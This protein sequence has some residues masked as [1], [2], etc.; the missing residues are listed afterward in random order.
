MA[1]RVNSKFLIILGA[2][3]LGGLVA[4][5]IVAGPI[6]N[7]VKGDRSKKQI[8]LADSL[9]KE[10]ATAEDSTVKREKLDTA[11]RNYQMA[12]ASDSRNPALLVKLGDALNLMT[13]YEVVVYLPA[14]RQAW[15]KALEID[16]TYLPAL[17]R[18]QDSYYKGLELGDGGTGAF[19]KL[20]DLAESIHKLDKKDVR[21]NALMYIAPLFR[22]AMNIET[23]PSDV[24]TAITELSS[25]IA[26]NPTAPEMP[27]MVYF[28]AR[29]Q[30]KK[31]VETKRGGQDKEGNAL[32]EE[33]RKTFSNAIAQDN[34]NAYLH[35]RF[36]ELLAYMRQDDGDRDSSQHYTEQA[37]AEIEKALSLVKPQDESYVKIA[38]AGELLALQQRNA[39]RAE[40]ILTKL[41][42][43]RPNDQR[44]RL[45][46]ARFWHQTPGKMG[47]A[48][49]LLEQPM[50]DA[51][52]K[53]V[54]A[55]QKVDLEVRSL[56]ELATMYVERFATLKPEERPEALKQ[57]EATYDKVYSKAH[58]RSDVLT[59]RG[60]L[61][62]LRGGQ[63]AAV[64]AIQTFEKAQAQYR[65]ET[66]G[67]ESL[68]LIYLLARAYFASH[69]TGE[70]KTQ[71]LKFKEKYPDYP[72]VRMMLAQ[73]QISEGDVKSAKENV[74]FLEKQAP[75]DP[76]VIRMV[77]ATLDPVK[78]AIRVKSCYEKLPEGTRLERLQKAMVA[79]LSPVSNPDD[80]LRLYKVAL[81]ADPGDFEA[82][83]G[84]R[85][86]LVAKGK[87][88]EA[89]ALLKAGQAAKPDEKR[90]GLVL[91]QLEGASAETLQSASAD[92]IKKTYEKDPYTQNVKLYEFYV[93][94]GDKA[95]GFKH[96]Q[97]AEKLKPDDGRVQDLMFQY[98]M[99]EQEW[100]KA[101]EYVEKLAAK[102]WDQADGLIYRYRLAM[103]Q[104]KVPEATEYARQLTQKLEQ[105]ARSWIFLGQAQQAARQYNDAISSYG[106]A[107]DK[108]S[109][110]PEA[111]AGVIACYLQMNKPTDAL[112]YIE[113]GRTA[114]PNNAFF[115]EQWKA[116]MMRWGNPAEV[117]EPAKADR[118][119]NPT[120]PNRWIALGR[121]QYAAARKGDDK[122]AKYAADA[123]AT[124]TEAR[125]KWPGEKVLWA[126]LSEISDFT[127]DASGGEALLK[128][129][130]ARPEFKDSPEPTLMLADHYLRQNNPAQAE[131]TMKQAIALFPKD[132]N[133]KRRLAAFYTQ[134]KKFEEALALLEPSSSDKLVRQQMVE[135]YL[136]WG[137][138]D[139]SEK[140]L[141]DLLASDAKDA[142]LHAL[143][144]VVLMNQK[145]EDQAL[146]SLTTALKLDPKNQAALFTRGQLYLKAKAP[147]LD[148]AVKD[149]S[150][151]EA[152]DP[153]NLEARLSLAEALQDQGRL[154]EA[155][156]ELDEALKQAPNRRDV[157]MHLAAV[158][159]SMKPPVWSEAEKVVAEAEKTEPKEIIWKRMLAKMYSTR[160]LH[161]RAALKI[162]EALAIDPRNGEVFRDYLD[163]LE[164]GKMWAQLQAEIE[165]AFAG[166]PNLAKTGWWV[167]VKRAVA[168]SNTGHK[169]EGMSDFVKAM[170]I[171]QAD[172]NASQDVLI[173]IIEKI[174]A[175]LGNESAIERALMLAQRGGPEAPR[176]KVVVAYLYL[177]A[178][179]NGQALASI[180]DA[181][182]VIGK[183]DERNALTAYSVAGN[184]YMAT[185]KYPEAEQV[186]DKLL[187]KDPS[188]LGALNNMA[189]ILAEHVA[190]PDIGKAL[191]YGQRAL[192]VMNQRDV[193]DAS[194]L[195]T[196][197]WMNVLAGGKRVDDGIDYLNNSLKAG[198]MAE[199]HYHLGEAYLLKKLPTNAK[200]SLTRASEMI[201]E[202]AEKKQVVDENLKKRVDEALGRAEKAL[203]ETRAGVP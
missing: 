74:D 129:M 126:F 32:L 122:S 196:V 105:F 79:T 27:D 147:Q 124:F 60:K 19:N 148:L 37:K 81:A 18:L 109:E 132:L 65:A 99:G 115:R 39:K 1:R 78:D 197:G 157:R 183:L 111:I 175:T 108:Q 192:K 53:G 85:E 162:R 189:C 114:H 172:K 130:I 198:E 72:P 179:E 154:D 177:Q 182:K 24:E 5:V 165:R 104:Q 185:G 149:L 83:N 4:A 96:L 188:D 77:L 190:K 178:G 62:L 13:Q 56:I 22:Y 46:M 44:V 91:Q 55:L 98:Y 66:N 35:Y 42:A 57:L 153:N 33:G 158:Y 173:S 101:G 87:K 2:V 61:E 86:V 131:A 29:A 186:Y 71:L 164:A 89:I 6:K 97:E 144:G 84:A 26:S 92:L 14:S 17:H 82:L 169:S 54:E 171:V 118:D 75:E 163:I 136:M 28:V 38:I 199:A 67:R 25:L 180:E 194:V 88:N 21:A 193:Q 107:L 202:K 187:E 90:I 11:V 80:A 31:G 195:D 50:I 201:Q 168:L 9:V 40:A 59:I 146:E 68:D 100:A 8:E 41:M 110:N 166:D 203:M 139:Q 51:G 70:A 134:N 7:M 47:N 155:A 76:D 117:I 123:K 125:N 119:A 16:P 94:A 170:E 48:I 159:A 128:Q 43:D 103:A 116:Y 143:L 93:M 63:D 121:A 176:W 12:V 20:R 73:I 160:A 161:E 49:T 138:F 127:K 137:K 45:A 112:R 142:Q 151:A 15:E 184:I 156:R 120:D 23:P 36:Y 64:K 141:R 34:G 191:E 152:L 58:E 135:I 52:W 167:Y 3:I 30:A 200:S 133:V 174:R 140:I 181:L 113:R 150:A 69:Q 106:V 95:Q 102:K 145:H 10:A